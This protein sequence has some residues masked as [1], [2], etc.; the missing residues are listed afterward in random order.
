M[1][2]KRVQAEAKASVIEVFI[3]F[4]KLGLTSFGGPVAH[5][6][7]FRKELIEKRG[8]TS[9]NQFSQLL[10]ICQFLPGPAS[11]QLGFSLGLLRAGWLGALAAFIAFTLPSA[12]LLIAFASAL[13]LLLST[14]NMLGTSAIHGLKLVA[15]AVV[16][17]AVFG[18]AK[19]LCPDITRKSIA[20]L[21]IT[22]LLVLNSALAQLYVVIIGAIVGIFLIRNL[23]PESDEIIRVNYSKRL[24]LFFLSAFLLLL[25]F[26]PSI[27]NQSALHAIAQ[28][29][30]NA[31]ALVFGGGHVV[32][33]LLEESVVAS[34]WVSSEHF[35]AGYGASQAIPGP[36][37]AFSAYLGSVI[38]VEQGA[39]SGALIALTFMFLPGFLL[40]SAA[41]PLWQSI[42]HNATAR[43]AIAGVNAAVVGL[44]AAALYNPVFTSGISSNT[45]LAIAI[46]GF[47][48]LNI[49]KLSPL[50]VVFWCVFASILPVL[51]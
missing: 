5:I 46:I 26:L 1:S 44:L 13:P 28:S 10:A 40:I 12:M 25:L 3:T 9:E 19:K 2:E 6:G 29:F 4:L 37:F 45:D 21:A 22:V 50:Y 42:A 15:C 7:Y 24:G 47:G 36:M 27:A 34:G 51:I 49:W 18:M 41:L 33:P 16:A 43:S 20:L 31:G 39:W 38:P 35:L 48:M 17:D 30:Y 32:L 23:P 8:W 14:S 11:S